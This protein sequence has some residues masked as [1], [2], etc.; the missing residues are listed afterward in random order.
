MIEIEN[1]P[2][3]DALRYE[4]KKLNPVFS[5]SKYAVA[6]NRKIVSR[7]QMLNSGDE[8]ALLPQ[9]SGG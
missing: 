2:D 3:T 9:F 4:I 6:V 8:V 7:N 5:N 1:A